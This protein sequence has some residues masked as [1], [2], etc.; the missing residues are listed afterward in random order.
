MF[1]RTDR[2]HTMACL[3]YAVVRSGFGVHRYTPLVRHDDMI[4]W[5]YDMYH[6][7]THLAHVVHS[8]L[9]GRVQVEVGVLAKQRLTLTLEARQNLCS[10]P[11]QAGSGETV[12]AYERSAVADNHMMMCVSPVQRRVLDITLDVSRHIPTHRD[13]ALPLGRCPCP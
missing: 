6:I 2:T 13:A 9:V 5:V 3:S 8:E 12:R 1:R 7:H 4:D 11:T 10:D